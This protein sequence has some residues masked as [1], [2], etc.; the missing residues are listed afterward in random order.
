MKQKK[1]DKLH[2]KALKRLEHLMDKELN[3][4]VTKSEIDE[5]EYLSM[6]IELFEDINY[7]DAKLFKI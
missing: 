6:Y 1:K 3:A 7:P 2:S 5:I 4:K